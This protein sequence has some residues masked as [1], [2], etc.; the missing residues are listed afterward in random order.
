[1]HYFIVQHLF[2]R[3]HKMKKILPVRTQIRLPPDLHARLVE[4]ASQNDSSLN[5]A[6]I[7][8]IEKGMCAPDANVN[9]DMPDETVDALRVFLSSAASPE[10]RELIS[11]IVA[12]QKKEKPQE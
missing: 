2:R 5:D 6:M 10:G 12:L 7:Y 9:K 11:Q 8:Y 4:K 3:S 1:M